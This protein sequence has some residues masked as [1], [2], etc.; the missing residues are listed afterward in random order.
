MQ[1]ENEGKIMA[2]IIQRKETVINGYN[3]VVRVGQCYRYPTK[4]NPAQILHVVPASRIDHG[5]WTTGWKLNGLIYSLK[6][7]GAPKTF[8]TI[9]E[10]QLALDEFATAKK[11]ERVKS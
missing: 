10:A 9:E 4:D 8:D 3:R 6:A 2:L 7:F 5:R 1:V 11:L